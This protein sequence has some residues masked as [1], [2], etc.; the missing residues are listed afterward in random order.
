MQRVLQML[1]TPSLLRETWD[2][3]KEVVKKEPFNSD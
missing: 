2:Y 1:A 3:R